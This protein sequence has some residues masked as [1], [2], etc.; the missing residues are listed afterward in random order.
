[1]CRER[2]SSPRCRSELIDSAWVV[3]VPGQ[4]CIKKTKKKNYFYIS[5]LFKIKTFFSAV[6]APGK[7]SPINT[8][9]YFGEKRTLPMKSIFFLIVKS[10][11]GRGVV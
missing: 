10:Y 8:Y 4:K 1:M 9:L 3:I 7:Y 6:V 5:C 2:L 11:R